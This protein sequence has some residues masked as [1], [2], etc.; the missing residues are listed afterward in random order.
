MLKI[1]HTPI[2]TE[3]S[4][5]SQVIF[6]PNLKNQTQFGGHQYRVCSNYT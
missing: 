5:Q 6:D 1:S 4:T 3:P 2:A